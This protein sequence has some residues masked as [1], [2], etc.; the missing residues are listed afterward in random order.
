MV[1]PGELH[2]KGTLND[3]LVVCAPAKRVFDDRFRSIATALSQRQVRRGPLCRRRPPQDARLCHRWTLA[4][5]VVRVRLRGRRRK[6]G[7]LS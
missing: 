5:R 1:V 6:Q 3:S 4:L 2:Q 7:E